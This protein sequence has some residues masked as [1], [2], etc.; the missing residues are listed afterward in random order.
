MAW[1]VPPL[2]KQHAGESGEAASAADTKAAE[3]VTAGNDKATAGSAQAVKKGKIL[4]FH[5][6]GGY[7]TK[8][9]LKDLLDIFREEAEK[10]EKYMYLSVNWAQAVLQV[11]FDSQAPAEA[12]TMEEANEGE[13]IEA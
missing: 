6:R 2:W 11:R 10:K 8:D 13:T 4:L 9:V 12:V 3:I 5:W 7:L 1:L